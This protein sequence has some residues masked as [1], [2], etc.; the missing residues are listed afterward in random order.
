MVTFIEECT[1]ELRAAGYTGIIST[2]ETVGTFQDNPELCGAVSEVIHCNIH[3]YYDPNT[4]SALAGSFVVSQQQLAESICNMGVIVSETG[5]P[6]AGGIN[7]LAVASF[8]DQQIA[9][10]AIYASTGGAVTWFSPYDDLWK[11]PGPEQNFGTLSFPF[12]PF[13][14]FKDSD[15][16]G[17]IG[18]F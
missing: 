1:T 17:L 7:G 12:P 15:G 10:A 9:V 14:R 2:A 6:S 5:W 4:S 18:L 8:A 3:G 16:V 13:P 11:A